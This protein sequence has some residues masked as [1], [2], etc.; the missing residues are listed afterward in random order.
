MLGD[1]GEKESP[2]RRTWSEIG[3]SRERIEE[4]REGM[5][6]E[7]GAERDF[8]MDEGRL[9]KESLVDFGSRRD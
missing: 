4:I 7:E 8:L 5:C 6:K 1:S 9:A 2:T 3:S